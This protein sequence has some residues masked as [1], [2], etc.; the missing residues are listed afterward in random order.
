ML[1]DR[2]RLRCSSAS[3]SPSAVPGT[4]STF[5]IVPTLVVVTYEFSQHS[6][7]GSTGMTAAALSCGRRGCTGG[8]LAA[9]KDA[10]MRCS[11]SSTVRR[12][13]AA[14]PRGPA[15][16]TWADVSRACMYLHAVLTTWA[17]CA[18]AP[19]RRIRRWMS[20]VPRLHE[21]GD[22][23]GALALVALYDGPVLGIELPRARVDAEA[24]G[25]DERQRA[26]LHAADEVG[27]ERELHLGEAKLRELVPVERGREHL[28]VA[29]QVRQLVAELYLG[30]EGRVALELVLRRLWHL[31]SRSLLASLLAK[32][33]VPSHTQTPTYP[34]MSY[35]SSRS[36]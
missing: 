8:A 27:A 21:P 22:V 31:Q 23:A 24:L 1:Y 6:V 15:R 25:V 33:S 2:R 30:Y 34:T 11:A 13:P 35:S 5:R 14:A 16:G 20:G 28:G 10:S 18:R 36:A 12:G 4:S 17:A 26:G 29:R 7:L 9:W 19:A 32:P 3:L